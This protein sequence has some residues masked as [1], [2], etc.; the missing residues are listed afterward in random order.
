MYTQHMQLCVT[1]HL[2][3]T[4]ELILASLQQSL[5]RSVSALDDQLAS[6]STACATATQA[7]ALDARA[8]AADPEQ[9][10]ATET[11]VLLNC[12]RTALARYGGPASV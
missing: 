1:Q 11:A 6:I 9:A 2:P 7:A 5:Q 12:Y 3:L 8:D 10:A 4:Q